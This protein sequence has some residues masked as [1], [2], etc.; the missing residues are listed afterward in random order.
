MSSYPNSIDFKEFSVKNF[1]IFIRLVINGLYDFSAS[2]ALQ[3]FKISQ[4]LE[5][6]KL[7]E[8]L[9][10]NIKQYYEQFDPIELLCF[11]QD[12][13]E[14]KNKNNYLYEFAFKKILELNEIP[15]F[16]ESL[17]NQMPE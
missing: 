6:T 9:R 11:V 16:S 8:F 7:S 15:F 2:T 3:L 13:E 12:L 10:V 5:I 4:K 17:E 14:S 1:E